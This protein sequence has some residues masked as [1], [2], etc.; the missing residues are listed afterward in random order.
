MLLTCAMLVSAG[1]FSLESAKLAR[2]GE[3]NILVSNYGWYLFGVFPLATGNANA[4]RIFPSVMFRNDVRMD[5]VQQRLIS[6]A[7]ESGRTV[8]DLA[9]HNHDSILFNIPGLSFP[10]PIPYVLTYREIQLSG[11]MQ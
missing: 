3:E 8:K 7:E 6:Y 2:S 1:C 5:K 11:V 4:D 9:Y 10:I